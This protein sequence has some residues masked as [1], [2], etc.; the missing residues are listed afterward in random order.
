MKDIMPATH[1]IAANKIAAVSVAEYFLEKA[2]KSARKITNK[3]IQKLVYYA[4]VW[5]LVLND[6]QFFDEG[7]EAWVHG[8][9]VPSVYKK[10]KKF[11]FGAIPH[12]PSDLSGIFSRN[13]REVLD[14]VWDVY[15][16]YDAEYLEMLSH[17]E[18]PW[19][20]ARE[21]FST[22]ENSDKKIDLDKAK[23]FYAKKLKEAK[24][25]K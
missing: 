9:A 16:K 4:Q 8:P 25:K 10:Y 23:D 1:T 11:G 5:S 2:E 19:Q 13:Q 6:E 14:E 12:S 22:F 21:G 7:I 20:L 17:S 15:G 3:K 18:E 24:T